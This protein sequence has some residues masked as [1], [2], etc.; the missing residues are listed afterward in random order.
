MKGRRDYCT[1]FRRP[2]IRP[3]LSNSFVVGV[4][5]ERETEKQILGLIYLH[6]RLIITTDS[7]FLM[8]RMGQNRFETLRD[9]MVIEM[10]C[11]HNP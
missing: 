7:N 11:E 2:E 6:D 3:P 10:N 5:K 8:N 9:Y 1:W 4:E